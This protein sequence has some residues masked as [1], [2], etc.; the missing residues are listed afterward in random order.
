MVFNV[1]PTGTCHFLNCYGVIKP[2]KPPNICDKWYTGQ[3]KRFIVLGNISYTLLKLS[4]GRLSMY[5]KSSAT[6]VFEKSKLDK[7]ITISLYCSIL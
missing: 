1:V 4:F 5:K 7:S 6:L 3:F 2:L